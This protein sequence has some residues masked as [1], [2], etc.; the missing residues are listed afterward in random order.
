MTKSNVA[1]R[2]VIMVQENH[3]TDNYFRSM[4]ACGANVADRRA[5]PTQ[6]A[7]HD[8]PHTRARL[9]EVADT[10]NRRA[11]PRRRPYTPSSTRSRCCRSTPTSPRPGR[12]WRTTVRGSAPTPPPT[13]C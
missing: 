3:T 4:R 10:P 13:T 11:T 2:V 5:D 1:M 8:H 12:S 9:L 7:H 6:P